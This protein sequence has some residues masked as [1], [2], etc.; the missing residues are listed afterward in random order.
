MKKMCGFE[1]IQMRLK[2]A[3][4]NLQFPV[5]YAKVAVRI[6]GTYIKSETAGPA[7]IGTYIYTLDNHSQLL[8]TLAL[9]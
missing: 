2:S 5:P 8:S 3:C 4:L 7:V 9:I 6:P 1:N